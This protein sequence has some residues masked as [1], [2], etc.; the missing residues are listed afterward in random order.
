[1][2]RF[3]QIIFTILLGACQNTSVDQ[4]V[5]QK[6]IHKYGFD[7]SEKEW[8]ERTQAGQVITE[9]K[10]GVKITHTYENGLLHGSTTYTFA[11]S[12]K[13]EETHVYDQ[14]NLLKKT[15]C[16]F[17][18][19][20]VR[21][22]VYEFDDRTIITFWDEKGVPLSLEEYD[23]DLLKEGKYFSSDHEL[24]GEVIN[25]KGKR[26]KRDRSGLLIS[27]DQIEEGIM[28]ART[29]YHPNG[30]M[31]TVSH[32]HDYQL[33][34]EQ[35]KYTSSG[36]PLMSLCWE[37][38]FLHGIK[39][40]YRNGLKAAEVPYVHGQKQDTEFQYDDLGNLTAEILWHNDKKHGCSKFYTENGQESHWFF[41]GKR[42]TEQKFELLAMRDP[43]FSNS[44]SNTCNNDEFRS[45]LLM[46]LDD[47]E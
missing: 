6:F 12:S 23:R 25:G 7:L 41:N 36:R 39:T 33:H 26:I 43:T 40:V 32:Y 19:F 38:G 8:E 15:I 1:M 45:D 5:S 47:A 31:H 11:N 27:I 10:N 44:C 28:T 14:G 2:K 46:N 16:D 20:P 34:G 21:E 30:Q 42:V 37:H 24:T 3:I 22:E 29:T 18:G 9:L 13:I 17:D 4:V 35:M